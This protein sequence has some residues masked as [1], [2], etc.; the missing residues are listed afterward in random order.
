LSL[1]QPQQ[2]SGLAHRGEETRRR[3]L[4]A[5]IDVF[6][7]EGYEAA[8]TRLLAERSGVKLPAIQYYFGNKEGLFRAVIEYIAER[9]D[10][11][12]APAADRAR[13][14]LAHGESDRARLLA[15]MH[16]LLDSF[17]ENVLSSDCPES[18]RRIIAR[19]EIENAVALEPLRDC[20]MRQT[21]A[22]CVS[23]IARLLGRPEAD[24]RIHLRAVAI[25]GQIHI[26][27]MHGVRGGFG[28]AGYSR[29]QVRAIQ[30]IVRENTEA[31]FA[32]GDGAR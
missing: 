26:F 28:W 22:P 10:E 18:W 23:L 9:V 31:I 32:A 4:D 7:A 19:G 12:M 2:R 29:D 30:A 6:A 17:A 20:I 21:V 25:L 11:R 5:A 24:E 3:I 1:A 14:G 16:E 15:L 13:A 8:H 27:T